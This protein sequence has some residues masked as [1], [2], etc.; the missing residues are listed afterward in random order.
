MFTSPES[1]NYM[2]SDVFLIDLFPPKVHITWA[3]KK[4]KLKLNYTEITKCDF[5]VF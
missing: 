3:K 4:M 2:N 5:F 1:S